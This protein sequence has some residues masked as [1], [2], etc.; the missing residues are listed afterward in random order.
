MKKFSI[1][2]IPY[3]KILLIIVTLLFLFSLYKIVRYQISKLDAKKE[4]ETLINDYI[5]IEK[6]SDGEEQFI[7]DFDSL[8]KVNPNVRGW[9]R[10]NNNKVSYPIVQAEDNNYYLDHDFTKKPNSN[11]AIFM[12][13]RNE[14][15]EDCN[16]VIFGHNG[17]A[18]Y[19][20][21]SLKN[22]LKGEFFGNAGN[23]II[24]IIDTENNSHYYE[25]FSVYETYKEEY[26]ITT[27]FESNEKYQEFLNIIKARSVI[28]FDVDLSNTE[29]IVTLSTCVGFGDTEK[30]LVVHARTLEP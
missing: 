25:V 13:Y 29:S 21:G 19:M 24:E 12:D 28:K 22:A 30:R 16:V 14:S 11:G 8:L 1:K 7:V 17:P 20:F 4:Q 15:L 10:Y 9:I 2:N 5:I 26:Y 23:D 6:N 18:N 3:K 27:S